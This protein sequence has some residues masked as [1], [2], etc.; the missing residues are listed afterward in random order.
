MKT[1]FGQDKGGNDLTCVK[2]DFSEKLLI[3]SGL[4]FFRDIVLLRTVRAVTNHIQ[5]YIL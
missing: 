1:G 4:S 2:L 5:R 3:L